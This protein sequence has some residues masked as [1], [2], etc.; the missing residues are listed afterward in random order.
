MDRHNYV[1][2]LN[3]SY[4]PLYKVYEIERN[5][6]NGYVFYKTLYNIEWCG[7]TDTLTYNPV[8]FNSLVNKDGIYHNIYKALK[9]CY[10]LNSQ[11]ELVELISEK[12]I[13]EFI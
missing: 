1:V 8:V 4:S 11:Y 6:G 2:I 3:S 7:K 5:N 12:H 9:V 13:E 10:E